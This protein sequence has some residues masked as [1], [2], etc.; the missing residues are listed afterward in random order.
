MSGPFIREDEELRTDM[1][2]AERGRVLELRRL[3][4]GNPFNLKICLHKHHFFGQRDHQLL[5]MRS[6]IELE[7][8]QDPYEACTKSTITRTTSIKFSPVIPEGESK[9][10]RME[11]PDDSEIIARA[12]RKARAIMAEIGVFYHPF[13]ELTVTGLK[14][15]VPYD[16]NG[17]EVDVQKL[18]TIAKDEGGVRGHFTLTSVTKLNEFYK[19]RPPAVDPDKVNGIDM[20]D[21]ERELR[22]AREEIQGVLEFVFV[23]D[24]NYKPLEVASTGIMGVRSGVKCEFCDVGGHRNGDC[25]LSGIS[26]IDVVEDGPH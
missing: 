11:V 13:T 7:V 12:E 22:L 21:R 19:T 20:I 1:S 3:R 26:H 25:E 8:C 18:I 4:Q 17:L 15:E 14:Y 9:D 2:A 10:Q 6:Y 16:T 23:Q 5:A 24:A